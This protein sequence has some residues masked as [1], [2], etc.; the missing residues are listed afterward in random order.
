VADF[1]FKYWR[2]EIP[3]NNRIRHIPRCVHY[4]VQGLRLETFQNVYVGSGS[5]APEL[6]SVSPDWFECCFIYEKFVV[7]ESSELLPNKKHIV[8]RVT[9]ST[10]EECRL[11][12]SG[13]VWIL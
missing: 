8:A 6:Y 7:V 9:P 2:L 3:S 5:R 11:L 13:A 10:S 1:F 12:G 4:D